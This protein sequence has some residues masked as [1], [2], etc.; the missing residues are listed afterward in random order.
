MD[1]NMT[2]YDGRTALHLAASE[3]HLNAVD[4]LVNVCG[5]DANVKD[6]WSHTPLYEA[7]VMNRDDVVDYLQKCSGYGSKKDLSPKTSSPL[8]D[9]GSGNST[10]E[11]PQSSSPS[12]SSEKIE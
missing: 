10:N 12:S 2:D 4:F 7:Q 8:P 5:V 1:M 11:P 6:R 9:N 3:G